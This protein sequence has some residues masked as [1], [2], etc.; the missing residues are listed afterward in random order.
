MAGVTSWRQAQVFSR[1]GHIWSIDVTRFLLTGSTEED[2]P[3]T[4]SRGV[5]VGFQQSGPGW[6]DWVTRQRLVPSLRPSPRPM[7]GHSH[8]GCESYS[9]GATPS[10]ELC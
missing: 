1:A 7:P 5:H 2:Y 3:R 8:P 6:L 9:K 4:G 10:I